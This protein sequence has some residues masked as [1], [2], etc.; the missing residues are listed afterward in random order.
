MAQRFKAGFVDR[1]NINA[2]RTEES[3]LRSKN[4]AAC[5]TCL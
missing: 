1:L 4:L 2:K 5:K 3:E